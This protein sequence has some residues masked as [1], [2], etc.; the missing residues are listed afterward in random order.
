M[1][2]VWDIHD[3]LYSY[4]P[5]KPEGDPWNKI[6]APLMEKDQIKCSAWKEE[7][8]NLLIFVRLYSFTRRLNRMF[9]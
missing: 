3:D 6:L 9:Y 2:K 7:V 4:A 5:P 8:Q 1:P